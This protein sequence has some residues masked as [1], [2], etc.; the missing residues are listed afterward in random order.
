MAFFLLFFLLLPTH[1]TPNEECWLERQQEFQT[2]QRRSGSAGKR[3]R[4]RE[5]RWIV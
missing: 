5:R 4:E 1:P 2:I 3:E